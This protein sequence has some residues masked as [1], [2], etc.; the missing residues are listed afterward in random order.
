VLSAERPVRKLTDAALFYFFR[1][2]APAAEPGT[3]E[4]TPLVAANGK[5][6]HSIREAKFDLVVLRVSVLI[7]MTAYAAMTIVVSAATFTVL[8]A[9]VTFGAGGLPAATSLALALLP[10]QRDTGKLFGGLAMLNALSTTLLGPL[11]FGSVFAATV[12]THATAVFALAGGLLAVAQI[13]LA[14]VRVPD[15]R[16]DE[17]E[18]RGRS[19]G[20][21]AVGRGGASQDEVQ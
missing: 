6:P 19:R 21:K 5:T 8:T 4:Q 1:P 9:F 16:V 3:T 17:E 14:F 20:S 10:S 15:G 13:I 2:R 18:A 7:E 12:A 11:L